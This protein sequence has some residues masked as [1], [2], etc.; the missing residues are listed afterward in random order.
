M[1]DFH[2]CIL[3]NFFANF[4]WLKDPIK[5]QILEIIQECIETSYLF[6]TKNFFNEDIH[7]LIDSFPDQ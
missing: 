7:C 5:G 1:S 6:E 4:V 3:H 2:L